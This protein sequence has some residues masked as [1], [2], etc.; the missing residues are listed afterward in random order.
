MSTSAAAISTATTSS[1]ASS[2]TTKTTPADNSLNAQCSSIYSIL[3]SINITPEWSSPFFQCC[4]NIR[5]PGLNET[6]T[7]TELTPQQQLERIFDQQFHL[8][9]SGSYLVEC[10]RDQYNYVY[11][12]SLS[13]NSVANCRSDGTFPKVTGLSKLRTLSIVGC[14]LAAAEIPW[15]DLSKNLPELDRLY[16]SSANVSGKIDRAVADFQQLQVLDLSNNAL[17]GNVPTTI[18]EMSRLTSLNL[19]SNI[20]MYGTIPSGLSMLTDLKVLDLSDTGLSGKVPSMKQDLYSCKLPFLIC[21]DPEYSMP[22]ACN[23]NSI[24]ICG[25]LADNL[26]SGNTKPIDKPAV[27]GALIALGVLLFLVVAALGTLFFI[28]RRNLKRRNI[29]RQLSSRLA[30]EATPPATGGMGSWNRLKDEDGQVDVRSAASD[31]RSA[32][33]TSRYPPTPSPEPLPEDRDQWQW[34]R[35]HLRWVKNKQASN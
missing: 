29:A 19:S 34:D 17:R 33:P 3:K 11:A 31:S 20:A 27:R 18:V 15:T 32:T 2:T 9:R 12:A 13:I 26:P 23:G 6:S 30:N 1:A 5:A 24:R 4:Q 8:A 22:N 10:V 21:R 28:R 35:S 16:I 7:D 14:D 25:D